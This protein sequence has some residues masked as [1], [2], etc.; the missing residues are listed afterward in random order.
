M[1][2]AL[3]LIL[4]LLLILGL[5][6]CGS[7]S[8]SSSGS[9]SAPAPAANE[10]KEEPK[11]EEKEPEAAPA[12]S[13]FDPS[14]YTIGFA[15]GWNGVE[16]CQMMRDGIEKRCAELGF[17]LV[18]TDA[19][20]SAEKQ[21]SDIEDMIT[22]KVDVLLV[23]TYHPE[24]IGSACQKAEDAGIPVI[25][26]STAVQDCEPTCFLTMDSETVGYDAGK[27]LF[28]HMGGSGKFLLLNGKE[29]S[30]VNNARKDGMWTA[31]EEYPDIECCAEITCNYDRTLALTATEDQ[32]RVNPDIKGVFCTN[33]DM[34][35]GAMQA[36]RDAG[37]VCDVDTG[38]VVVSCGDGVN[39]ELIVEIG[40]NAAF[41]LKNSTYGVEGVDMA[42]TILKGEPF[43]SN[44]RMPGVP[45]TKDN[46]EEY[47]NIR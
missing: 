36:L 26:L 44:T 31:L 38:V 39:D 35:L 11:A 23:A 5:A 18:S 30:T 19:N 22:R 6:A 20:D 15:Q 34:A 37:K 41:T 32:L 4:V 1:K 43:E 40:N 7:T 3:S 17:N 12:S 25:V 9:S 45:I 42:M 47:R 46:W 2:K 28:E 24:A 16:F 14:Q 21:I 29:T 27:Y 33:D 13:E 10:A 8:S